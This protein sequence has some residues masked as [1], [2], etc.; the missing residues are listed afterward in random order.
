MQ[1]SRVVPN[2]KGIQLK[3]VIEMW[4][5]MWE[6]RQTDGVGDITRMKATRQLRW[7]CM[8]KARLSDQEPASVRTA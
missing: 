1:Q 4:G 3:K 8:K 5:G 7:T 6:D 2:F